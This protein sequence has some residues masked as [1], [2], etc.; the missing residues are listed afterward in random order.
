MLAA[1]E[2]YSAQ[3]N[4]IADLVAEEFGGDV[5]RPVQ[6]AGDLDAG[7]NWP[8]KKGI[9]TGEKYAEAGCEFFNPL[10]NE[11]L[12]G[13]FLEKT[14]ETINHLICC[15]RIILRDISPNFDH[16]RLGL[17]RT[18][19]AGHGLGDRTFP[20][21]KK[22]STFGFD[23]S[24]APLRTFATIELIEPDLHF[25]AQ[26]SKTRVPY[27]FA[28]AQFGEAIGDRFTFSDITTSLHRALDEIL[29]FVS[30][31]DGEGC[32]V[33]ILS[34]CNHA[35]KVGRSKMSTAP[36]SCISIFGMVSYR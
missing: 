2:N 24:G 4:R 11:R 22:R 15:G 17:W 26:F 27:F 5:A 6:D 21:R 13:E 9:R 19:D 8:V 30:K 10:S 34:N 12:V 16:V 20:C 33:N 25:L 18:G 14:I 1:V 36:A 32:H 7:T 35:G 3:E 29:V 31:S 23:F 28:G